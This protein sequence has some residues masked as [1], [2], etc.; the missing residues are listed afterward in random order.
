MTI[1]KV[2]PIILYNCVSRSASD[3]GIWQSSYWRN[4]GVQ[5]TCISPLRDFVSDKFDSQLGTSVH[6]VETA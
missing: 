2:S 5:P 6:G 4:Y 3:L 1:R